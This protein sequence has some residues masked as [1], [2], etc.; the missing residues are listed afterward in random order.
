M[1]KTVWAILGAAVSAAALAGGYFAARPAT[2]A[3]EEPAVVSQVEQPDTQAVEEIVRNYLLKNPEIIVEVQQALEEK[4]RA[5]QK[6]A[7]A[8]VIQAESDDIFRA[9]HDGVVGNPNG[10][11]TVVE[12]YDYNCG[13]CKRAIPTCRR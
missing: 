13:F 8:A 12:F 9:P 7:S 5:E 3:A 6:V 4:Q 2:V 11:T 1:Q 10:K